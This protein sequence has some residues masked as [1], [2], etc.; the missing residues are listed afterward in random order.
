MI[1]M[2]IVN[3]DHRDIGEVKRLYDTAFPLN[4]RV[5]FEKLLDH[6][7]SQMIAFY[8]KEFIGF[9]Y[10]YNDKD[11]ISI[12]YYTIKEDFRNQGYGSSCLQMIHELKNEY[13]IF[14]DIEKTN[15]NAFNREQRY[16]RKSFYIKN[17]YKETS[18]QYK[19]RNE[20]YEILS[21][22]SNLT[23]KEFDEF[24]DHIL[25]R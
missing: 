4:E 23:E 24:W 14:V 25:K 9:V 10:M 2:E 16:R 7:Q 12:A 17:G 15:D 20:S 1:N 18:I 6:Q 21:Y 5:P 13:R 11:I 22:G 8:D 3:K 19:W